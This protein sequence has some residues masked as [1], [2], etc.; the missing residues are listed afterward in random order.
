MK[1]TA[2]SLLSTVPVP[3]T[4]ISTPLSTCTIQLKLYTPQ[5]LLSTIISLLH[6]VPVHYS[7]TSNPH[8][9]CTVQL[10]IYSPQCL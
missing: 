8:I 4:Y 1:S 2:I 3:Y 6:S 10:Y 9:I 5:Y 7:N